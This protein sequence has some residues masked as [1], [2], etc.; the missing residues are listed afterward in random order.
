MLRRD[1]SI[2]P[3]SSRTSCG[4]VLSDY[5]AQPGADR[6]RRRGAPDRQ[7][8]ALGVLALSVLLDEEE[9][10]LETVRRAVANDDVVKWL[11]R[12]R[13]KVRAWAQT[14]GRKLKT[15]KK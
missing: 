8:A 10:G 15:D 2:A 11:E 13:P 1:G 3:G 7:G 12:A 9:A 5:V 6:Q 4:P 14:R